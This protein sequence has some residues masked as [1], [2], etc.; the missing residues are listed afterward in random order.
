MKD[1]TIPD[2]HH[3]ARLCN[4]KY[5]DEGVIQAGAFML[6]RGEENLSV[7]W[8]EYLSCSTRGDEITEVRHIYSEKFSRVPTHAQIAVLNVGQ[9]RE[10]V[11][12]ESP[13]RRD[14]NVLHNPE[15]NDPVH[16]GIYDLKQDDEMIAELILESVLETYSAHG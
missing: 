12:K 14:L 11:R 15:D 3:V 1:D 13:D 7:D 10:K 4:P 2:P 8:L 9:M 16:S 5:I 6:K